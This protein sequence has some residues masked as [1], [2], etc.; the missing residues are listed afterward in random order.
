M[1]NDELYEWLNS[2]NQRYRERDIPPKQRPFLAFAD[3][4]RERG[5]SVLFPS[6]TADKIFDWFKQN[7]QEGSHA[8]GLLFTGIYY[9]DASLWPVYV[10]IGFGHFRLDSL[11]AVETMPPKIRDQLAADTAELWNY[12][13]F[14]ADCVDLAYGS[15]DLHK[16]GQLSPDARAFLDNGRR[17]IETAVAQLASA[18]PNAKT[19][20]SSRLAIE[21]YFKAF[22]IAKGLEDAD[23]VRRFNH[24]LAELLDTCRSAGL[25]RELAPLQPMLAIFP[26]VSARYTG[27]EQPVRALWTAYCIAQSAAAVIVRALSGR[28]MQSQVLRGA[29][30]Q[31]QR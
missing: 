11:N 3:L 25:D 8:I 20:L 10:S 15:D 22:L 14:W 26:A 9:F 27:G 12:T 19:M 24:R 7:T 13:L 30:Q 29:A 2:V 31:P 16:L 18:H 1:N 23:T 5:L 28:D 6:A 21:V 17:E 4:A